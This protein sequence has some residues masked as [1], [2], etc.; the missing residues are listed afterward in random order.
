MVEKYDQLTN[1]P[2]MEATP[3]C[4]KKWRALL[5]RRQPVPENTCLLWCLH[6][7]ILVFTVIEVSSRSAKAP[8]VSPN[9]KSSARLT[10]KD[11]T[12]VQSSSP[13]GMAL[14]KCIPPYKR[15]IP[16]SC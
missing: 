15:D 2:H 3:S 16:Q 4:L 1:Q 14:E 8:A 7:F 9:F 12:P 5:V 11:A 6:Y 10:T 13:A